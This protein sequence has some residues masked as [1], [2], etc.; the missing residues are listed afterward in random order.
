M[1]YYNDNRMKIAAVTAGTVL[2]AGLVWFFAFHKSNPLTKS[3]T[4]G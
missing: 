4:S 3:Q 2:V 1:Y